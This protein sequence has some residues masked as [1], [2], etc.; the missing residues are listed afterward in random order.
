MSEK[1]KPMECPVCKKFYFTDLQEGDTEDDIFCTECGWGYDL[2]QVKD[3][4]LKNGR[5]EMSLNEYKAWYK[6][7]IKQNP[8][9]RYFDQLIPDP[10]PHKCPICG[11]Y[12]FEDESSFDICPYCGWE[13]DGLQNDEPDY[14]GGANELSLNQYKKK[15]EEKIKEDPNYKWSKD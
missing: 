5:N 2:S 1:F 3:P 7:Q 9:Y 13:D 6:Q 10:V 4:N 15:Y 12:E 14:S 8:K 11:K